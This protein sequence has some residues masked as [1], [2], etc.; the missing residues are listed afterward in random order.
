LGKDSHLVA[1]AILSGKP[2]VVNQ[3]DLIPKRMKVY[4]FWM[5]LPQYLPKLKS[6]VQKSAKLAHQKKLKIPVAA[7]YPLSAIKE[8][9][10][11]TLKGE[12]VLLDFRS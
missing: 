4:G 7:V 8:A 10:A 1:Y 3:L 9:V 5:Y 11:H 6:A 2:I 12:K